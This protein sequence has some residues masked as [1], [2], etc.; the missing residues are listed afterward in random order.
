MDRCEECGC[1][2]SEWTEI[3]PTHPWGTGYDVYGC[4]ECGYE[5]SRHY[6]GF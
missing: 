3:T 2:L 1:E 5:V 6:V 4:P